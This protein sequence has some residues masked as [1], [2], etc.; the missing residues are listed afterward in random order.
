MVHNRLLKEYRE[1]CDPFFVWLSS[2]ANGS[3]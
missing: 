2:P 3:R 1:L